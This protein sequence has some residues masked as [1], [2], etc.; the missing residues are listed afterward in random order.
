MDDTRAAYLYYR[1]FACLHTLAY[2]TLDED[3]SDPDKLLPALD[4]LFILAEASAADP[5]GS[6]GGEW[7]LAVGTHGLTLKFVL[8]VY[9]VDEEA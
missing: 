6:I 3:T 4:E 2:E 1:M 9:E 8:N 5:S 7:E